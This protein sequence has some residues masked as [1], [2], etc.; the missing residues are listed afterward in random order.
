M[1]FNFKSYQFLNFKKKLK[2][3]SII[4]ICNT[5][6]KPNFIEEMQYNKNLNFYFY[7]INNSLIKKCLKKSILLNY[8]NMFTSTIIIA[9]LNNFNNFKKN[10]KKLNENN[11]IVGLNINNKIYVYDEK[12][13]KLVLLNFK[14]DQKNFLNLLKI[15]LKNLKKFRNNVI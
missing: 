14:K 6:N 10:F 13:N 11:I 7:K 12:I 3:K 2:T 15:N 4:Y 9:E 1:C 5:K 8:S